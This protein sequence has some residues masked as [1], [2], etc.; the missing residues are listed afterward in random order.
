MTSAS[1]GK[2]PSAAGDTN[3]EGK[4]HAQREITRDRERTMATTTTTTTTTMTTTTKKNNRN[5]N[6]ND[7]DDKNKNNDDD[8]NGNKDNQNN[9]NNNNNN[10][11]TPL[12]PCRP[13]ATSACADGDIRLLATRLARKTDIASQYE[14][15]TGYGPITNKPTNGWRDRPTDTAS[16]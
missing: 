16:Y 6:Y 2:K 9:N 11:V 8:K 13:S 1:V 4:R 3:G 10:T 7:E 14:K 5:D 12:T 15:I